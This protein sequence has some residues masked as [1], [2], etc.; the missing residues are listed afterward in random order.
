MIY[1]EIF[2]SSRQGKGEM[3]THWLIGVRNSNE[4]L[5][6]Y[7][8]SNSNSGSKMSNPNRKKRNSWAEQPKEQPK[9]NVGYLLE[10]EGW[11]VISVSVIMN[12]FVPP[13]D[14]LTQ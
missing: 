1:K 10:R 13:L 14:L 8:S 5:T 3:E 9:S 4:D 11:D 7:N 2:K 12:I 6:N